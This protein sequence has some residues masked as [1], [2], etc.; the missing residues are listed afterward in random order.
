MRSQTV[1][2]GLRYLAAGVICIILATYFPAQVSRYLFLG[3][4][5]QFRLAFLGLFI[6]GISSAWGILIAAAGFL[7][8]GAQ[9]NRVRLA[10]TVLLLFALIALFFVLAYHSCTVPQTHPQL[11]PGESIDI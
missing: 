8:S 9:E 2:S 1:R 4:A 3:F 5:D 6:G 10:P 7:Q 11:Q